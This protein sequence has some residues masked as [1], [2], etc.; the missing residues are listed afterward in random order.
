LAEAH[1]QLMAEF[2]LAEEPQIV[3]W[4]LWPERLQEL[5]RIPYLPLRIKV[6][7]LPGGQPVEQDLA[8]SASAP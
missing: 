6:H 2:P 4:P 3:L 8:E 1:E 5:E 7:I